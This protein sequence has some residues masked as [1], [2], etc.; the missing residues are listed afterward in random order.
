[1]GNCSHLQSGRPLRATYV[2]VF[3]LLWPQPEFTLGGAELGLL[4]PELS[5]SAA[6]LTP[7]IQGMVKPLEMCNNSIYIYFTCF[8]HV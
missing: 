8:L 5:G 4:Q 1:M 2:C 6:V 7:L 3:P